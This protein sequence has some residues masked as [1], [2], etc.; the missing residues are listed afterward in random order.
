MIDY[1]IDDLYNPPHFVMGTAVLR[2]DNYNRAVNK[3]QELQNL[4]RARKVPFRYRLSRV[5][6][7]QTVEGNLND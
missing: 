2:D 4:D 6:Y 7:L 3:L 1:V 5:Q